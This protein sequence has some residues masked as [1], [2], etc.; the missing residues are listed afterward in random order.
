MN[1]A[2]LRRLRRGWDSYDGQPPREINIWM[3]ALIVERISRTLDT[4]PDDWSLVPCSDGSV[5]AELHQ[6]GWD[7]EINVNHLEVQ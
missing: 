6:G 1:I 3:A 2:H 5:Q 7:I 4:E